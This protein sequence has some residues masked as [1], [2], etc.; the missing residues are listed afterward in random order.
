MR[1][2]FLLLILFYQ[3]CISPLFPNCCRFYPTC[4]EYAKGAISRFGIIKGTW[5]SFWRI[6]RCHPFY[7][8]D[9]HDPVPEKKKTDKTEGLKD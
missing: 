8:G 2:S 7:H 4:S 6:M 5:L 9:F 3:K 1:K